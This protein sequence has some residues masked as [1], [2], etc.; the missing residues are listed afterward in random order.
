[1]MKSCIDCQWSELVED[2]SPINLFECKNE[3]NGVQAGEIVA[4]NRFG[5]ADCVTHVT[6]CQGFKGLADD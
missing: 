1:M 2:A 3:T 4:A 6:H 5:V